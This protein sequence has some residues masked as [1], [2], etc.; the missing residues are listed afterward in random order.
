[1]SALRRSRCV[2]TLRVAFESSCDVPV[3]DRGDHLVGAS[4][5][6]RQ[7]SIMPTIPMRPASPTT[8]RCR[9]CPPNAAAASWS[10]GP[11]V[12]SAGRM[13][14]ATAGRACGCT[15]GCCAEAPVMIRSLS[16]DLGGIPGKS[17]PGHRRNRRAPWS[18]IPCQVPG[19]PGPG[20]GT[21]AP[22]SHTLAADRRGTA[23]IAYLHQVCRS[24]PTHVL[25]VPDRGVRTAAVPAW[26]LGKA[27]PMR[28]NRVLWVDFLR[29]RGVATVTRCGDGRWLARS[30]HAAPRQ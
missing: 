5:S 16:G 18:G 28:W 12:D 22:P 17:R 29:P 27:N 15:D 6:A 19:A 30:W 7:T 25:T 10:S 11:A 3:M 13:T 8:G 1:M 23:R 21:P 20:R 14:S 4:S 24:G 9:K 26:R 2:F